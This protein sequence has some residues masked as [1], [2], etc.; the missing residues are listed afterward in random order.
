MEDTLLLEHILNLEMRLMNYNYQ[1]L[2]ELL[3]DDFLEFGSS[4]NSY[5]KKA[6]IDSVKRFNT[7]N[8]IQLSVTNFKIKLLASD[9]LLATYKTFRYNDSKYALRSS[10]WKKNEVSW[11]MIFHQGTHTK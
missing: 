8:S 6:I 10:I 7:S 3:A 4:G 1:E 11:Q 2:D 9:V 5:D